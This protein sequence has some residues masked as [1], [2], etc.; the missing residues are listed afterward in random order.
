MHTYSLKQSNAT[1]CTV[2]LVLSLLAVYP[3]AAIH[4]PGVDWKKRETHHFILIYP[5]PLSDE[6]AELSKVM[7]EVYQRVSKDIPPRHPKNKWPVVITDMGLISNGYVTL[8]PRRSIWYAAADADFIDSSD[9]LLTLGLHEGRHMAQFDAADRGFTRFLHF[10]LGEAGWGLGIAMAHPTWLLEGDAVYVETEESAQGRGRSPLFRKEMQLLA[11]ENPEGNYHKFATSSYKNLHPDFYRLGYEWIRWIRQNYGEKALVTI[12]E[13]AAQFPLPLIGLD[14]GFHKATQSK[15]KKVFT[16]MLKNLALETE[17]IQKE[18]SWTD[19][20]VMAEAKET[21]SRYDS[22]FIHAKDGEELIFARK[23]SLRSAPHLI[24]I[25]KGG[26]KR[27]MRLPYRGRVSMAALDSND[28]YRIAWNALR[29]HP[30]FNTVSVSDITVIDLDQKGRI[31]KTRRPVTSS[32]YL[33]PAL[34]HSGQF[35]AAVELLRGSQCRLVIL[36]AESGEIIHIKDIEG[37]SA[38]YPAWSPDDT[39]LVF[40]LKSTKGQQFAEWIIGENPIQ[41]LIDHRWETLKKP[42]YSADGQELIYS[43]NTGGIESLWSFNRNSKVE[44]NVAR[45]FIAAFKPAISTKGDWLYF[46]EYPSTQGERIV[47]TAYLESGQDEAHS[48]ETESPPFGQ[49]IQRAGTDKPAFP[50]EEYRP[51]AEGFKLHSWGYDFFRSRGTSLYLGMQ[52]QDLLQ[53]VN[54]QFG[55][56][57]DVAEF[58]PGAYLAL[59]FTGIRPIV[60]L[61]SEYRYRSPIQS[62]F[63]SVLSGLA[64][65]YPINLSRSGIWQH[66]LTFT[67]DTSLQWVENIAIFPRLGYSGT[68]IR[69]R[70]G[71]YRAFRPELGWKLSTEFSHSLPMASFSGDAL[72]A[73]LV[74]HLPG[75]FPN[76]FI[77][78]RGAAERRHV[79]FLTSLDSARGYGWKNPQS[80]LLSSFDYEF[81]LFYPDVP[82]GAIMSIKRFRMGLHSD[83][84]WIGTYDAIFSAASLQRQ[85]SSGVTLTMD[86]NILE[87]FN[88]PET[89]IGFDFNWLWDERRFSFDITLQALPLF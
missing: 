64:M 86:L 37:V 71:S 76:T 6:I 87:S 12:Y 21:G 11:L 69:V 2:L 13:E 84:A 32:R 57:Y 51:M 68:W 5:A 65:S 60:S 28:G 54:L 39:R 24:R 25:S 89:S 43:K 49:I 7:D 83:F 79:L 19:G 42:I 1:F 53:R 82:V 61:Y 56:I 26:E 70:P 67:V 31:I 80:T 88:F 85:W 58:S 52:F 18:F 45:R 81:P 48:P 41:I 16:E 10:L 46:V 20:Q 63:H 29:L 8:L 40:A 47:R 3:L 17:E 22:L 30:V 72:S 27:L 73:E 44:S 38:D 62:P 74:F 36:E 59:S 50:E 66:R 23:R 77:T 33:Y 34:S 15:P 4:P 55:G 9:W 14:F 78:L 75:G 35:I